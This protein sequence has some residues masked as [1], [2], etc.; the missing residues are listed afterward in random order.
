MGLARIPQLIP[1]EAGSSRYAEGLFYAASVTP[2]ATLAKAAVCGMCFIAVA[3]LADGVH[4]L[5]TRA[6][7][8]RLAQSRYHCI[9]G[10][11]DHVEQSLS[12]TRLVAFSPVG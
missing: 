5:R 8:I 10:T 7:L 12:T 4:S 3:G 11:E 9:T 2:P 1:A 6:A